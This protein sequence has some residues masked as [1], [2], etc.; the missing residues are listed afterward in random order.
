MRRY[1]AFVIQHART[2]F[3]TIRTAVDNF[4]GPAPSIGINVRNIYHL[5]TVRYST[6]RSL[7]LGAA[8]DMFSDKWGL[9]LVLLPERIP[10][11]MTATCN[12]SDL[13][14]KERY[15][16]ARMIIENI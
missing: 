1:E 13:W 9:L 2:H 6:A 5:D 15:P 11:S 14:Q 7:R 3:V 16:P 8:A 12:K 4:T 10:S